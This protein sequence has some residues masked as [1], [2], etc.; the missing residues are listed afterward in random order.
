M[1]F[2]EPHP[3]E[4][5]ADASTGFFTHGLTPVASAKTHISLVPADLDLCT[6]GQSVALFVLADDHGGLLAA[7]ADG[8]GFAHFVGQCEQGGGAGE[9]LAPEVDP[10]AVAHDRDVL[11]VR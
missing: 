9:K 2:P 11:I 10:E 7:M 1:R 8:A 3:G 4:R 6:I 5:F